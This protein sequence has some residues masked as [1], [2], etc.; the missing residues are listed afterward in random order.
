MVMLDAVIRL[1]PGALGDADSAQQDSFMDGLLDCS[2]YTRPEEIDGMTVP[3]ILQSGNHEAIRQWRLQQA[4]SRTWR[5]R[6]DLLQERTLTPEE[7]KF[8]AEI[9]AASGDAE[10][11]QEQ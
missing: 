1:L 8:L 2:H 10:Q 5:R 3:A 4:L 7:E 6:P 9:I 11:V